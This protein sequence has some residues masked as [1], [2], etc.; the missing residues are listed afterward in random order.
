M[1]D[2][3]IPHRPHG[4]GRAS[5]SSRRIHRTLAAGLSALLI[6]AAI[7]IAVKV[8]K[9][10][11]ASASGRNCESMIELSLPRTTIV[12]ANRT[13]G[14]DSLPPS[15]RLTA[16]VSDENDTG[17][18]TVWVYLPLDGWNGRFQAVGGGGYAG[19]EPDRLLP[20][21]ESGYASAGTDAGHVGAEAEF[22]LNKDGTPN[23]PAIND[24]AYEG[25]E[26]LT[27]TGKAIT[28]EFYGQRP[29]YSYFNGCSTGGRQGLTHA[30]R[31]G[32]DYD[33]IVAG[34]PVINFPRL[35]TG[36]MWGQVVMKEE[37][38]PV[39]SCKFEAAT[40]A[41]IEKC[42]EVGDG[43]R[44]G[45]IGDPMACDVDLTSLI[46]TQTACGTIS[47]QD[48]GV[49]NKIIEGPRATD[50]SFLWYGL[51]PGAPMDDLNVTVESNGQLVGEPFRYTEW[52][53]RLFV[54]Q[55]RSWD[56]TTL[57]YESFADYFMQA[58]AMYDELIAGDDADLSQFSDSGGKL[59]VWHGAADFGVPYQGTVDY[60]ER[61]REEMSDT[62]IDD[63]LRLFIAPGVGHCRGGDGPNPVDPMRAL[64]DW[65]EHGVAPDHLD[66]QS[67]DSENVYDRP[68]CQYPGVAQWTGQG[69]INSSNNYECTEATRIIPAQR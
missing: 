10:E 5:A 20:A 15:C 6:V 32:D 30:Q 38:N 13:P 53:L 57:T 33:G 34:A 60:Y 29:E 26:D 27:V 61:V 40:Q 8:N 31:F 16:V 7:T 18:V 35:Q 12:S 45:V 49:I 37:N 23:T 50:G 4:D 3:S 24:F 55:D 47:A 48:V 21:L 58:R 65:V 44:D 11:P 62:E 43:V 52:W 51:P 17:E 56:W 19:G 46:G 64:T 63:F 66:A 68:I 36:Q 1:P 14:R 25:I 69:S 2:S 39:A 42:D 28:E 9:T 59:I 54:E 22:A 41:L 67:D